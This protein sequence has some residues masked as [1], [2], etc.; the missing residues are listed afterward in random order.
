MAHNVLLPAAMS[1]NRIAAITTGVLIA[2]VAAC[3][4]AV[5]PCAALGAE[6][7]AIPK[8]LA[9]HAAAALAALTCLLG[10]LA[11][12]RRRSTDARSPAAAWLV[13]GLAIDPARSR[14]QDARS[15]L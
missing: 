4:L 8:E 13:R 1:E 2:G 7:F 14:A 15:T 3:G 10:R 12:V 11:I 9:V 6:R 5:L